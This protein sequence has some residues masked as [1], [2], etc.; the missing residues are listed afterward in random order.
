MTSGEEWPSLMELTEISVEGRSQSS[1][2]ST[3]TSYIDLRNRLLRLLSPQL[4]AITFEGDFDVDGRFLGDTGASRWNILVARLKT[5][6]LELHKKLDAE[7]RRGP[8]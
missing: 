6:A 1:P 8:A 3:T 4:Q 2:T 5:V 7:T